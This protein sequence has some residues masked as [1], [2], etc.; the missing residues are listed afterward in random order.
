MASYLRK[1][2]SR[3]N[4][5]YLRWQLSRVAKKEER[6]RRHLTKSEDHQRR[7]LNEL[8]GYPTSASDEK[9]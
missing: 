4:N 3:W 1:I 8:D 9:F 2:F 5:P 7:K 6:A